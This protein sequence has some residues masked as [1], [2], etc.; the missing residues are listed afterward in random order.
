MKLTARIAATFSR[1]ATGGTESVGAAVPLAP[2][3]SDGS[4]APSS[5]LLALAL[6]TCLAGFALFGATLAQA[7]DPILNANPIANVSYTSAKASG[8]VTFDTEA[9]GGSEGFWYFQYC[10][11][12]SP[13]ECTESAGPWQ[14]GPE[15][16]THT[17][18]AG[19]EAIP[20]E[21]QLTGLNPGTEYVFRLTALP[22]AGGEF[23]SPEPYEAFET[24]PVQAPSI[25]NLQVSSIG[26]ESAHVSAEVNPNG[27]DPAF[28]AHWQFECT[29]SCN[30]LTSGTV[31]GA[32]A[33][34][35][36]DLTDLAAKTSYTVRLVASNSG[37]ESEASKTFSTAS[38]APKV[39]AFAAGPVSSDQT[40][41]NAEI[42]PESSPTTYWFEWGTEDCSVG[43]CQSIPPVHEAFAGSDGLYHF[44]FR[45]L[46]G[47]SPETT[48][49]FRIVAK[50]AFGTTEGDDQQFTTAAAE[51]STCPNEAR[52]EEQH[53]TY[54]P[55]CRAYEMVS[56]PEKEGGNVAIFSG[57]TFAAA[58]GSAAVFT[59][60]T[61]FEE[62]EGMGSIAQY[63]SQREPG[64]GDNGWS[65]H[66]ITPKQAALP[67][68]QILSGQLP[69]FQASFTPDLSYGVYR[70]RIPLTDDPW[71]PENTNFYLRGDLREGPQV[72]QLISGCPL[73]EEEKEA[74]PS[75]PP[76]LR[77]TFAGA[78]RDLSHVLFES[79]LV[80][81]KNAPA[82]HGR[83]YG[84]RHL[85]ESVN[86]KVRLVGIL[87]N[88]SPAP[89][90]TTGMPA[91]AN[92]YPLR[93]ISADGQRVFFEVPSDGSIYM[94]EGGVSTVQLNKSEK[95]EPEGPQAA[96]LFTASE[97]GSRAFFITSEGLVNQDNN[98]GPDV[99]MYDVTKPEGERLT[100]ISADRE[101]ADGDY[102][103]S[104]VGSSTNGH[105]VYFVSSGQLVAGQPLL[106]N[107]LGLYLWHD[108]I[109]NYIGAFDSRTDVGTNSPAAESAF[110]TSYNTARITPDGRYILFINHG[111][112]GLKGRGGFSG[113]DPGTE[114][115]FDDGQ[116]TSCRE[117][118]LYSAVSGRLACVS[119]G[120]PGTT[121][122]S[123]ALEDV[124][125][126]VGAAATGFHLS[127]TLSDNGR[128]VFFSTGQSLV[129]R[130]VNNKYDAYA[131]DTRTGQ[132]RLLSSGTSSQ[133][134]YFLDASDDGRDA[135]FVTT[136]QLVGW[137]HDQNYD[138]YDA[139]VAGGFAEPPLISPLCAG[140]ACRGA[141]AAA[142]S[143]PP[144]GSNAAQVMGNL[145]ARSCS[146]GR[147][148]VTQHG[149]T[150]CVRG[151][152][153]HHRKYKQAAT[154]HERR[155]SR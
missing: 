12:A 19:S 139:R 124:K 71:T 33:T 112:R 35:E 15:A 44:V 72:D 105:Y 101:P 111:D 59:S 60:F 93:M 126:S 50:N 73:C 22:F 81:T 51:P 140:E 141:S 122:T 145:P 28:D 7:A 83:P 77:G 89:T 78:S 115:T 85:Y 66:P 6:V 21:E 14:N 125:V 134:S 148:A 138:L 36:A 65:S 146:K 40:D 5:G 55:D 13:G 108:G 32:P 96:T 102:P 11:P 2:R 52:R 128:L 127:Q 57:G 53:S 131:Y 118:Y 63:Q 87:P 80:L 70:S 9:N 129:E 119:C 54:L 4:G 37:G 23:H 97:D 58:D 49:H 47:L 30:G 95:T 149:K 150:V 104:I 121:A 25:A 114:C 142:P 98:R 147:R 17:L 88:G 120:A 43:S 67:F 18:P 132:V 24:E 113:Y 123:D 117:L 8:T 34:V 154:N 103:S 75:L 16:F 74:I 110:P 62:L 94:R 116:G 155:A 20:V 133:G 27:T 69:Q 76:Q 64:T 84:P 100:L 10:H 106:G 151:K 41:I 92:R 31:S 1:F 29:P 107:S 143:P 152:K 91:S 68:S 48:Y 90:S 109:V 38:S 144:A 86:G 136:Q 39:T 45:H 82:F 61:G 79:F 130:D 26:T 135:F 46:S 137:D 3:S 56:P 42:D 153:R 99:Y